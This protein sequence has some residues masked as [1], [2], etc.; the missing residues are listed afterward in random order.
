MGC[1]RLGGDEMSPHPGGTTCEQFNRDVDATMEANRKQVERLKRERDAA[2]EVIQGG[3]RV[4][5]RAYRKGAEAP[6][7]W[8]PP[9]GDW[10]EAARAALEEAS[11]DELKASACGARPQWAR[12]RHLR[13]SWTEARIAEAVRRVYRH[14]GHVPQSR[15]WW[16]LARAGWALPRSPL[17]QRFARTKG[18]GLFQR[19]L[20][21][22]GVRLRPSDG[23]G[24]PVWNEARWSRQQTDFL[25]EN[26]GVLTLAEIGRRLGRS[27]GACRRRLFD[28]GT[29]ARTARGWYTGQT[30]AQELNC[31]VTRV[32]TALRSGR[33]KGVRPPG[34]PYWQIDPAT[35]EAA[36]E[37]LCAPKRTHKGTPP[38]TTDWYATNNVRR[39]GAG[40]IVGRR[41]RTRKRSK[42]AA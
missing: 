4:A 30:V 22:A 20:I 39:N 28:L 7:L 23:N 11:D 2:R 34:R 13:T 3:L 41:R 35:V 5:G 37:W 29:T 19:A 21:R 14:L 6:G 17:L 1:K 12:S 40:A 25:L 38:R 36:R 24:K 32:Y 31:P 15:E 18:R 26:A 42:A 9:L 27:Y 33:L 16:A 10:L 8:R